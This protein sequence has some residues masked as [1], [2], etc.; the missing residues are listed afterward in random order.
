MEYSVGMRWRVIYT[1]SEGPTGVAPECDLPHDEP[2]QDRHDVYDCCPHPHIETYSEQV[3]TF[4]AGY[5]T[6]HEV[7]MCS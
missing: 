5:M 4:L 2:G 7:G 3:A 1:D 6:A